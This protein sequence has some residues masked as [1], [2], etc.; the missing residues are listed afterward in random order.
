M[1]CW[2]RRGDNKLSDYKTWGDLFC[3][4]SLAYAC[5]WLD[6]SVHICQLISLF[7]N[8]RVCMEIPMNYSFFSWCNIFFLVIC[9]LYCCLKYILILIHGSRRKIMQYTSSA[10]SISKATKNEMQAELLC[11][12]MNQNVGGTKCHGENLPSLWPS[13]VPRFFV[14]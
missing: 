6:E 12:T 1:C 14:T 2:Q 13:E 9:K 11:L 8:V 10:I 3:I 5:L 4:P 7:T